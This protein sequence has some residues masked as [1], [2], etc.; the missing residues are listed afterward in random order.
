MNSSYNYGSSATT[1]KIQK[2]YAKGPKYASRLF[3]T[4]IKIIFIL[5]LFI[6]L[7]GGSIGF[8]AMK[9]P[10]MV[11][12]AFEV[13]KFIT[14]MGGDGYT[15]YGLTHLGDYETTLF[16]KYSNNRNF[17]EKLALGLPFDKLAEG[18]KTS[19]AVYKK[20]QQMGVD[21]P[22]TEAV[23]KVLFENADLKAAISSLFNRSVK[24]EK[25][26]WFLNAKNFPSLLK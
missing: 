18:V 21:M 14:A 25:Y 15:A 13:S 2:S 1:Q 16:S 12:G 9:G 22:I 19:E 10:L 7:I 3:L 17:G 8:G 6:V 11:R 5:L 26:S 23:Y 4:I 24:T 20:A